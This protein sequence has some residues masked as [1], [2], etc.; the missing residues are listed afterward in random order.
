MIKVVCCVCG[1][2]YGAKFDGRDEVRISHG[3]C[4]ICAAVEMA[5]IVADAEKTEIKLTRSA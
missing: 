5:K 2:K 4:K 1:E 3:Y